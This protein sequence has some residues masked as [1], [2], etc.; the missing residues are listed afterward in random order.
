[1]FL[2]LL[3]LILLISIH[4]ELRCINSKRFTCTVKPYLVIISSEFTKAHLLYFH[5]IHCI[6]YHHPI[7]NTCHISPAIHDITFHVFMK[8]THPISTS[9][10]YLYTV[11]HLS[12]FLYQDSPHGIS[13]FR[14]QSRNPYLSYAFVLC[15]K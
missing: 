11:H 9:V 5:Q 4:H 10:A 14:E 8:L 13:R 7:V 6:T 12:S 3:L 2:L 1:M 15:V